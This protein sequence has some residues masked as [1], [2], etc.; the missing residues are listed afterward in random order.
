MN[1]TSAVT[2]LAKY[3]QANLPDIKVFKYKKPVSYAGAYIC[4]N[5]L[6]VKYGQWANST[7]IVNVN[8]HV[9]NFKNQQPDTKQLQTLTER[10]AALLPHRNAMT[11]DDGRELIINGTWYSLESD[12][13]LIED[14]DG[15]HF[16]NLR[17]QTTFTD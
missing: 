2:D 10:V 16:V 15:T 5:Y 8:I 9:P 4:L 11:E 12:S 1:G 6:A 3:I 13:G 14:T 17:V 7:G